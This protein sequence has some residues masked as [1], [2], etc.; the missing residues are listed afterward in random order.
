MTN[1]EIN[2]N[3]VV[4]VTG[5]SSGFGEALIDFYLRKTQNVYSLDINPGT[6]HAHHITCDVRDEN[7]VQKAFEII[8][9]QSNQIDVLIANA[10]VVPTWQSTDSLDIPDFRKVL[11]INLIGVAVTL[12]HAASLMRSPGGSIVITGSINSWKGDPN[13]ASYVASKHG[14]LGLIK[15]TAIDLGGKGIRVNGVGPGPVATEALKSRILARNNNDVEAA[16]SY[17]ER[18]AESTA[19]KRIATVDDVVHAI[20]F[21]AGPLSSGITGELI[22]VDGGVL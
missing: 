22:N 10:G 5:G 15:S 21:L 12:K 3:S 8:R 4:V 11:E 1:A 16:N 13:L 9:D 2:E 19:L 6:S 14:V 17:F 18:L 7:S 20:D